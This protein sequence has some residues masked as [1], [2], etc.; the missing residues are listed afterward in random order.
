MFMITMAKNIKTDK[1]TVSPDE[2]KDVAYSRQECRS[3][4]SF[5]GNARQPK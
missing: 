5:R 1:S 3:R 2:A 4:S